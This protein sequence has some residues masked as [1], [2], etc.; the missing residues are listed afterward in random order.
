MLQH[1][2]T[3]L[4]ILAFQ[5]ANSAGHIKTAY[6]DF[7]GKGVQ[8]RI[9]FSDDGAYVEI[10][11][12]FNS[13]PVNTGLPYHVH[14]W[15]VD[16]TLNPDARCG[17]DYVGGHYDPYGKSVEHGGNYT[18][19]CASNTSECEVGDLSGK[20][21]SLLIG[22]WVEN[23][24]WG[25][26]L[27]NFQSIVFR[28]IVI[29]DSNGDRLTCATIRPG[30][31]PNELLTARARFNGPTIGGS[32]RFFQPSSTARDTY[33]FSD[34]FLTNSGPELTDNSWSILTQP[35]G[36][37]AR[38]GI[39]DN[40]GGTEFTTVTGTV[41]CI[42]SDASTCHEYQL[43][44]K[45]GP[46]T[47]RNPSDG[48]NR[49]S[50]SE[51][52]GIKLSGDNSIIGLSIRIQTNGG[53]T[54]ACATIKWANFIQATADFNGYAIHAIEY[55]PFLPTHIKY[56]GDPSNIT[57]QL[58]NTE[59]YFT[60]R[61]CDGSLH[62]YSPF[63]PFVPVVEVNETQ[64]INAVG[65][66]T[67]SLTD[68]L[69]WINTLPLSGYYSTIGRT[70]S[71][72]RDEVWVC[73]DWQDD[74]THRRND[75]SY[76]YRARA[77]YTPGSCW[78]SFTQ[79][80][81]S[82]SYEPDDETGF[83]VSDFDTGEVTIFD[84]CPAGESTRQYRIQA[85]ILGRPDT[86]TYNP[87][88]V[89]TYGMDTIAYGNDCGNYRVE[90][91][92]FGDLERLELQNTFWAGTHTNLEMLGRFRASYHVLE[93][94]DTLNGVTIEDAFIEPA[95]LSEFTACT[96]SCDTAD[97]DSYT[98]EQP[99]TLAYL[100]CEMATDSSE[101]AINEYEVNGIATGSS[102]AEAIENANFFADLY[103]AGYC[104]QAT[105]L[106]V[107]LSLVLLS[108]LTY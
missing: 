106:F 43:T 55:S 62:T 105:A 6:A 80:V 79:R 78:V 67:G 27:S 14:N 28:S 48:A 21:V 33:I 23:D 73:S 97:G 103:N 66:L 56:T 57:N 42:A 102:D 100:S 12:N 19:A 61:D 49:K 30:D 59:G 10:A 108:L 81:S 98:L 107:I 68:S 9:T 92:E 88:R 40:I 83:Y 37:D 38:L 87:Y 63:T 64:D 25:L 91:C 77:V 20:H 65:N 53:D 39:C 11:T 76:I 84:Y 18:N 29:H 74:F 5:S 104:L 101:C 96:S 86:S 32:I 45:H 85:G 7:D 95:Y 31:A 46:L 22:N 13:L 75:D 99:H 3:F 51:Y 47:I 70:V 90:R 72:Q 36:T 41:T 52:D 4:L 17:S 15:P 58:I 82:N 35:T 44:E 8:G 16:Y 89:K 1:F 69:I 24:T 93:M 54:L 26:S 60:E 50:F 34:L 71:I 2:I 94:F